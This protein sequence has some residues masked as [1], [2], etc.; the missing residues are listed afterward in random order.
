MQLMSLNLV[1]LVFIHGLL[2]T[3]YKQDIADRKLKSF[4]HDM[5]LIFEMYIDG[6]DNEEL[7]K[8]MNYTPIPEEE[9][10]EQKPL[11]SKS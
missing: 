11:K 1:H 9:E 5:A 6:V 8:E 4:V 2:Q 3:F 10:E 7:K